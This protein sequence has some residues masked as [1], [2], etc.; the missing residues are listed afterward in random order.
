MGG[1]GNRLATLASTVHAVVVI[2]ASE[3][4]VP[5]LRDMFAQ[6]PTGFPAVICAVIHTNSWR[7]T[8]LTRALSVD[9]RVPIQPVNR[10]PLTPG[11]VYVAPADHHLLI[12]D[13]EALVW[14]G[15][16][17]NSYRPAV[18]AL[19]RSAAIAYGS[20]VIGVV[21][22]GA[23]EDGATGLWWIK[24]FG[25]VTVVQDPREALCPAMPA[26]AL[27]TVE[28]DHCVPA[29]ELPVLLVQLVGDQTRIAAHG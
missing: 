13:G 9:D 25:G 7:A 27:E 6:L 3:E 24:R 14:H 26:S 12:E 16:K 20:R 28:V 15:P 1:S 23:V 5:I 21:L 18:N 22:S 11:R 29:R 4:G 17:E 2:G 10:Q 8:A 19:F